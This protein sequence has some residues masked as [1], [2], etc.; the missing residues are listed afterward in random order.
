[1]KNPIKPVSND[2]KPLSKNTADFVQFTRGYLKEMRDLTIKSPLAASIL[3]FLTERMTRQNAIVIS[4]KTL[5]EITNSERTSVNK[6]VK[7]LQGDNWIQVVKIGS[8]NG[9]LINSKVVWRSHQ[10]KRYGYF[11]AEVVVSETEQTQSIEELENQPLKDIPSVNKG[12]MPIL[13]NAE[14]PPPDQKDLLEP[15][16]GTVPYIQDDGED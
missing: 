1:M 16:F 12:E 10:E 13:D 2:L 15:D 3:L 8:T 4:Q 5:A 7:L 11:N 14:L 6:A 9:Y